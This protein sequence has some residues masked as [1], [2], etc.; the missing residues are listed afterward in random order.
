MYQWDVASRL[1]LNR[2]G[3]KYNL[4]IIQILFI[5]FRHGVAKEDCSAATHWWMFIVFGTAMC[6]GA[7]L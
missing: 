5:H 7:F 3:G 6:G 4:Y 1:H 2:P